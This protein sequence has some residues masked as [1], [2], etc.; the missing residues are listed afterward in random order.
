M[1]ATPSRASRTTTERRDRPR[2]QTHH[3]SDAH[4]R[5]TPVSA[6]LGGALSGSAG[7]AAADLGGVS[8]HNR[9]PRHGPS[10]GRRQRRRRCRSTRSCLSEC[11]RTMLAE[12]V[13]RPRKRLHGHGSLLRLAVKSSDITRWG[14]HLTGSAV[15]RFVALMRL[16]HAMVDQQGADAG[17][18]HFRIPTLAEFLLLARSPTRPSPRRRNGRSAPRPTTRVVLARGA[19]IVG[20]QA[21]MLSGQL[22]RRHPDIGSRPAEMRRTP[23]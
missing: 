19:R 20:Q 18:D 8:F 15:R 10:G 4:L 13:W 5:T 23:A 21:S 2:P 11:L 6:A 14:S 1:L 7:E 9:V 17:R 12:H 16:R 22:T 3:S